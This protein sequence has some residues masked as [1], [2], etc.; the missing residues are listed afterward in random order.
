MMNCLI[1]TNAQMQYSTSPVY[2]ENDVRAAINVY[3][4][5]E[6]GREI[7][8]D[9]Y[10]IEPGDYAFTI[11]QTFD[12]SLQFVLI[13]H[14]LDEETPIEPSESGKFTYNFEVTTE[15]LSYGLERF[16]IRVGQ[17]LIT[18]LEDDLDNLVLYPNPVNHG[19]RLNLKV[20]NLF[21]DQ[22]KEVDISIIDKRGALISSQLLSP[23]IGGIVEIDMDPYSSGVYILRV[24]GNNATH[25]YK[26]IKN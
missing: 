24:T 22:I 20:S 16:A 11:D 7:P 26:V 3:D 13:D 14:F 18:S 8:L 2:T 23:G 10:N 5:L 15:E 4:Q 19:D 21:N 12:E 25:H 9:V 17:S 1:P 6:N